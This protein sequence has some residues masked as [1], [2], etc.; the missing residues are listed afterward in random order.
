MF[1]IYL[2][3]PNFEQPSINLFHLNDVTIRCDMSDDMSGQSHL[4]DIL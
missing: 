4:F 2:F 3:Y 1:F